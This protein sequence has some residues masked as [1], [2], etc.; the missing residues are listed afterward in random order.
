[1]LFF[2]VPELGIMHTLTLTCS[3]HK[4]TMSLLLQSVVYCL[5]RIETASLY[6]QDRENGGSLLLYKNNV[7]YGLLDRHIWTYS[8]HTTP[9][10]IV[11]VLFVLQT[12]NRESI[13]VIQN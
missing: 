2:F 1:M 12:T 10:I 3:E 11:A 5:L 7:S 8:L 13:V 4:R 9:Y 6:Q